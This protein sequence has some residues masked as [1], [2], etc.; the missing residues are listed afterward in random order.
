MAATAR[1][2][3]IEAVRGEVTDDSPANKTLVWHG[4]DLV[5]PAELGAALMFD[6]FAVQ[7]SGDESALMRA[8]YEM[9]GADGWAKAR[10]AAAEEQLPAEAFHDLISEIL[11][12]YGMGSGEPSDSAD[13][14]KN[15]SG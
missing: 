5:L 10:Q 13:S 1:Q 3:Q 2:T 7:V 15:G 4:V 6:V 9:V 11:A 8:I 12:Q 14:S